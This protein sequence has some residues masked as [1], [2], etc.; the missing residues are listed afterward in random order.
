MINLTQL[1]KPMPWLILRP[2]LY[3]MQNMVKVVGIVITYEMNRGTKILMCLFK[4]NVK[5]IAQRCYF[6]IC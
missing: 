6:L 4:R 1:F 3:Y 2:W 5:I